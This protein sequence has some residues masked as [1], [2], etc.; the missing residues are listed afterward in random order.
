MMV[1]KEKIY[2][3]ED[4]NMTSPHRIAVAGRK[5]GVG[6]TTISCG[7]A[8]IFAEGGKRVLIVDLDPQSNV[9]FTLG[10]KLNVPGTAQFLMG[11]PPAGERVNDQIVVYPGG[12]ELESSNIQSLPRDLLSERISHLDDYDVV[13]FDCPPGNKNLEQMALMAASVALIVLDSHPISLLGAMRVEKQLQ[14]SRAKGMP[15]APRHAVVLSKINMSRK[16]DKSF[17]QMMPQYFPDTSCMMVNQ[18]AGLFNAMAEQTPIMD[19][20]PKGR[21]TENLKLIAEWIVNG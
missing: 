2:Q 11:K 21:G 7:L 13:I 3:T 12:A 8:S 20:A 10:V 19:Y 5:G 17:P 14:A 1:C 18:D 15:I 16:L 6:K 9:A 4:K